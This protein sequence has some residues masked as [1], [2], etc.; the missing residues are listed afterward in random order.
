[1]GVKKKQGSSLLFL[2][3]IQSFLPE[4]KGLSFPSY[5]FISFNLKETNQRKGRKRPVL[6]GRLSDFPNHSMNSLC[7]N[8]ISYFVAWLKP[9]LNDDS[10]N[11]TD[12]KDLFVRNVFLDLSK[13]HGA[14]SAVT[15]LPRGTRDKFFIGYRRE[16]KKSTSV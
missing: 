2:S 13:K 9:R 14:R 11:P 1:M 15:S 10:E 5:L 6:R 8:S 12:S 16:I 3:L 4:G 7:S